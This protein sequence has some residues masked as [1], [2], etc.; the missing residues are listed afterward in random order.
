[1]YY[2]D[3]ELKH[4]YGGLSKQ[5]LLDNPPKGVAVR[6]P[7]RGIL[8]VEVQCFRLLPLLAVVLPVLFSFYLLYVCGLLFYAHESMIT[9][10]FGVGFLFVAG[11]ILY[12]K[13]IEVLAYGW[14]KVRLQL[15][16]KGIKTPLYVGEHVLKLGEEVAWE[17]IEKITIGD[18][19][20]SRADNE[21]EIQLYQQDGTSTY[22]Y[23][24]YTQKQLFYVLAWLKLYHLYYHKKTITEDPL[25]GMD[26]SNH[27]LEE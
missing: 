25:G 6:T 14:G 11:W 1:M 16:A 10:I 15:S 2:Y 13:P 20:A 18:S 12:T 27:L 3:E 22:L 8:E 21:K 23:D 7:S 4:Y 19:T 26:L 17:Y 9:L 5:E 24:Y